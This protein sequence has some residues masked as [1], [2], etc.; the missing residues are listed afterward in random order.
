LSFTTGTP[1]TIGDALA[2]GKVIWIDCSGQHGLIGALVDQGTSA[3]WGCYG[4]VTGATGS[5]IYTGLANTNTIIGAGCAP[6]GTAAQLCAAY[7][8]GGTGLP[9]ITNWYLPSKDELQQMINQKAV[10]GMTTSCGPNGCLYWTSTE[11]SSAIA[12]CLFTIFVSPNYNQ[13][14]NTAQYVRAVRAF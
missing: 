8:A 9:G 13:Y 6:A 11:Y 3:Q 5:A 1:Y 7:T 14:K 4:T 2:G 10:I 12:Y